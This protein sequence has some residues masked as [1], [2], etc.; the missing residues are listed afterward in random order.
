MPHHHR[1]TT[2]VA[3]LVAD[4]VVESALSLLLGGAGYSTRILEKPSAFAA[5]AEEQLAGVDLLLLMHSLRE[6]TR[7]G[8]LRAIES[9]PAASGVPVLTLSAAPHKELN[10]LTGMVPRPAPP[11]GPQ[12]GGR[13]RPGARHTSARRRRI[14]P[15]CSESLAE[16]WWVARKARRRPARGTRATPRTRKN[17]TTTSASGCPQT[18]TRSWCS[19]GVWSTRGQAAAGEW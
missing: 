5:N 9:T 19:C 11:G 1:P 2:T 4:P 16:T 7:E 14:G 10:G 13:G 15:V 18:R 17:A 12:A 3:I 8:F 6:E